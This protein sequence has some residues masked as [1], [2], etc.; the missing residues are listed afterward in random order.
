MEENKMIQSLL[1]ESKFDKVLIAT[2]AGTADTLTGFCNATDVSSGYVSYVYSWYTDEVLFSIDTETSCIYF[3]EQF[4]KSF[5][6]NDN[7]DQVIEDNREFVK[8][9]CQYNI[10]NFKQK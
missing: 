5:N 8:F 10:D 2:V 6:K 9:L 1:N 3:Y 4:Y 7:F